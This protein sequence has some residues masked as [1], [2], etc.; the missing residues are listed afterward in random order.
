MHTDIPDEILPNFLYLGSAGASRNLKFLKR[1]KI[2][3]ILVVC[4]D[5]VYPFFPEEGFNYKFI[6]AADALDY[7]ISRDFDECNDF[8][9]NAQSKGEA[10]IVH[11]MK[12]RSRSAAVVIAY[13]MKT[14][15]WTYEKA[16]KEVSGQ[17]PMVSPNPFFIRKLRE[18]ELTLPA[19]QQHQIA[20]V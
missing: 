13:L 11:C 5:I 2:T 15:D 8:I 18:Y 12:G 16:L 7:D 17:R 14:K 3:N 19:L 1:H 20:C 6:A 4:H 9:T 10:V